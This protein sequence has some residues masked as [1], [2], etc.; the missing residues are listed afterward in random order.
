MAEVKTTIAEW[1]DDVNTYGMLTQIAD[2]IN[3]ESLP[4]LTPEEHEDF[5]SKLFKIM[6]AYDDKYEDLDKQLAE[7]SDCVGNGEDNVRTNE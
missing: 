5:A 7:A 1:A 6:K 4:G 2:R 3:R